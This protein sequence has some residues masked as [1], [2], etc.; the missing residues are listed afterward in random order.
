[1]AD[2]NLTLSEALGITH[3]PHEV[4]YLPPLVQAEP[5]KVE[6]TEDAKND[7]ILSRQTYRKLIEKGNDA[8]DGIGGLAVESE[9]PRAYEVMATLMKTIAD[10]TGQL[11]DLQKKHKDLRTSNNSRVDEGNISIDRAVFVGSTADLLK[12]LKAQKKEEAE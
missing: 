10:T 11:Y 5:A 8:L 3:K 12:K 1:M 7:Y 2:T 9:S 4:E 6:E